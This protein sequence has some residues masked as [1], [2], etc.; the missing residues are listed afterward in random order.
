MLW[1][2]WLLLRSEGVLD[3]HWSCNSTKI[4]S[5]QR[6]SLV[7]IAFGLRGRLVFLATVLPWDFL[8]ELFWANYWLCLSK[9]VPV[10]TRG[11]ARTVNVWLEG[12][13]LVGH[14]GRQENILYSNMR[15]AECGAAI[16]SNHIARRNKNRVKTE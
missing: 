11:G 7:Q 10:W 12:I 4:F 6:S 13:G 8:I 15:A 2:I 16:V 5:P 3:V 9:E 14:D 1:F